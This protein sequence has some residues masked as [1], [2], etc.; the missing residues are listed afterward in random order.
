M[1]SFP[2][3]NSSADLEQ[4][5]MQ[6]AKWTAPD[7][8]ILYLRYAYT[9]PI[10]TAIWEP[11]LIHRLF[12]TYWWI[13]FIITGVYIATIYGLRQWMRDRKPFELRWPLVAWNAFLAVFSTVASIRFGEEALYVLL[14]ASERQGIC[15]SIDPAGPAA[16]W[17]FLFAISKVAEL[18]DTIFIVLRKRP[19]I[20][21]HWYHHAVVLVY[22]WHAATELTA[23][24][25]YFIFMNYCVHSIMYTYYALVS[26]GF[27][28][29]RRIAAA[30]TILQTAQMLI[31]VLLSCR[32]AYIKFAK[33]E[34]ACQQSVE[35]LAICF[36]IYLTFAVLFT[37]YFYQ[38]Y[39][40]GEKSRS[41][42]AKEAAT[43]KIE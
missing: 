32:V 33:P 42:T 11:Y 41:R 28:V 20:F 2:E 1:L 36:F 38:S 12:T 19:L 27:R 5:E 26:Y 14:H 22:S 40:D 15:Y 25:R 31:G 3:V 29:P 21:L 9:Y 6:A 35:N 18:V 7:G 34:L 43:K 23:A 8:E 13:C 4:G 37:H 39:I 10:E 17:A 16:L 24:G 30:V